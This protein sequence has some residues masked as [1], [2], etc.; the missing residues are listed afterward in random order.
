MS[1]TVG[2]GNLPPARPPAR[3]GGRAASR[4]GWESRQA[5]GKGERGREG[6]Q[7]W[8]AGGGVKRGKKSRR[9]RKRKIWTTRKMRTEGEMK[10]RKTMK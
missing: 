7:P 8:N 4:R 10:K 1:N 9:E 2:Q 3:L 6:K 5:H